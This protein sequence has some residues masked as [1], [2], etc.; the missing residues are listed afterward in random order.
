VRG[1]AEPRLLLLRI[2]ERKIAAVN[3]RIRYLEKKVAER[4]SEIKRLNAKIG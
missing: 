1:R 4:D 2:G 3:R